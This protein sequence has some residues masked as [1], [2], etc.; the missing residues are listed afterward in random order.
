MTT[1]QP[2]AA[3]MDME[4]DELAAYAKAA[5]AWPP[6]RHL[7]ALILDQLRIISWQVGGGDKPQPI[8][9][10]GVEAE[11][12]WLGDDV[13]VDEVGDWYASLFN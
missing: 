11:P 7:L 2:L 4:Q 9:R 5:A 1:G 12:D 6:D 3:L 8:P 10:P 13:P